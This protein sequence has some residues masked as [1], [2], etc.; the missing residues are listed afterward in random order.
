MKMLSE[1]EPSPCRECEA[2]MAHEPWCP[3]YVHEEKTDERLPNTPT[4]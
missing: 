1:T 2:L 3:F 4:E